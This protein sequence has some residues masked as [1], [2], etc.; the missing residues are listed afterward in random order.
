MTEI[1]KIMVDDGNGGQK[2]IYPQSHAEAIIDLE[3]FIKAHGGGSGGTGEKGEKGNPGLSAYEVAQENGYTGTEKEWL[4]SL[5]G[6]TGAK[7]A[8]GKNGADGKQ[9]PAGKDGK[10]SYIHI[11][12][13]NSSDGSTGFSTSDATNKK[14]IGTY[15]DTTQADSKDNRKYNWSLIKG[16]KGEPGDSTIKLVK[17]KD[18]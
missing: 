1:D 12:Y 4:A 5:K 7:G 18:V 14:Y 6:A 9:G 11:A 8:D 17:V 15:T 3:K 2:Q 16:E 10:S 13:A